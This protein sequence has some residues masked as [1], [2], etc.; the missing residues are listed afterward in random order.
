MPHVGCVPGGETCLV[1]TVVLS[2]SA[3]RRVFNNHSLGE[4]KATEKQID[5]HQFL[6]SSVLSYLHAA[7]ITIY[8]E[9]VLMEKKM[10]KKAKKGSSCCCAPAVSFPYPA[11]THT[12]SSF[13]LL[14]SPFLNQNNT[15]LSQFYF[16]F[17]FH[18]FSR[19]T[20]SG[21]LLT[22]TQW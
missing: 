3:A 19:E 16:I 1:A 22:D 20:S 10:K 21:S 2:S 7:Y 14:P 17:S 4:R 11:S 18:F 12:F 6:R 13:P 8:N 5:R 15:S 9:I